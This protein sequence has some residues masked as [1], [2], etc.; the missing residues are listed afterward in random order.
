M[1]FKIFA[2]GLLA[3]TMVFAADMAPMPKGSA[4]FERIKQLAGRWNGTAHGDNNMPGMS[5]EYKVTGGGSAVEERLFP[6][7]P[8]EMVSMYYD[9]NGKLTMTH[10]CMIGNRPKMTLESASPTQI[11]LN[12]SKDG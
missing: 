11:V 6:G 7:T 5:V 2:L 9:E 1:R 12:L 3:S 8:H 4:E 10:Y